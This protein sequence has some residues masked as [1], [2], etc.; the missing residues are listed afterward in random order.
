M[1]DDEAPAHKQKATVVRKKTL[2][3]RDKKKID[4]DGKPKRPLSAYNLFFRDERVKWNGE[5]E[6]AGEVLHAKGTFECVCCCCG[7]SL[8]SDSQTRFNSC[9]LSSQR[10]LS[11]SRKSHERA[12][13][14]SPGG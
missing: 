5:Q 6:A 3:K 14:V 10:T 13:D 2:T 8:V 1:S 12:L 7:R 9:L 4:D 11:C